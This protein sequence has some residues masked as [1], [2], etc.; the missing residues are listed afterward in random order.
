M[1]KTKMKDNWQCKGYGSIHGYRK[2]RLWFACSMCRWNRAPSEPHK[3]VKQ[4]P[5]ELDFAE[6]Y[7]KGRSEIKAQS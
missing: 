3:V 1:A 2:G 6:K 4:T 5:K 7:W